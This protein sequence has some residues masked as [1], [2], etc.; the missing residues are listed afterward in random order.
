MSVRLSEKHGLNP[1]LVKCY[2]CGEDVA[3]LGRLPGD[4]EAPRAGVHDM[5]PCDACASLM[6]RGVLLISVRDEEIERINQAREEIPNPYRTGGWIVVRDEAVSR[7]FN[8][9]DAEDLRHRRWGYIEDQVWDTIGFPRAPVAE[10]G[11]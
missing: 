6:S 4:A 8:A 5:E 9:E 2:F 1:S 10:E 3:P 11:V 7:I